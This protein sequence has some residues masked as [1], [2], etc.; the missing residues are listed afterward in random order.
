MVFLHFSIEEMVQ[1]GQAYI[2]ALNRW[3]LPFPSFG[4]GFLHALWIP[5]D[6]APTMNESELLSSRVSQPGRRQ[7]SEQYWWN[8][9]TTLWR[10]GEDPSPARRG[11]A[12]LQES[13]PAD[14]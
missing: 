8:G 5:G 4:S 10:P 13:A 6:R 9:A 2:S 7:I 1:R 12:F 3:P 11:Q 14:P